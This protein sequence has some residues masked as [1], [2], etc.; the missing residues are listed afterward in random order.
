MVQVL[1]LVAGAVIVLLVIADVFLTVLYARIGAGIL[2]MRIARATWWVVSRIARL[3]RSHHDKV[4]S[5]CGPI[6]LVNLLVVWALLLTLGAALIIH[7]ALGRSVTLTTGRTPTDFISALYA[8]GSSMAI[9]RASD[10]TPDTGPYRVYFL[11]NSLLGASVISLT[12]TYLMQVYN[13]LQR[14]NTLA[15]KL[16]LQTAETS[17]AAELLAGLGARG[18]F[19]CGFTNLADIAVEMTVSLEA[20]HFYPV[21]FYFRFPRPIYGVAFFTLLALDEVS[22]IKSAL[23][24]DELGW[25]K[26]SVPVTQ[27]WRAA[28]LLVNTQEKRSRQAG[29]ADDAGTP[30]ADDIAR[31]GRRYHAAVRRLREAGVAT[32]SDDAEGARDY[33]ALR[34]RWHHPVM[35]A[36]QMMEYSVDQID[37]MA[38]HP[39]SSDARQPFAERRHAFGPSTAFDPKRR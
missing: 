24:D 34:A 27:L 5:F 17:D 35:R 25:L 37:P 8:G 33:V 14:R 29:A 36:M 18:S 7:P 3:F 20:H 15:Y 38:Q 28:L 39:E 6:I 4:L 32:R 13:A 2:S 23:S 30:T 16:Y 10:V 22:L 9:V 26:E 11:F 19:Q 1:E 12:I 21:L 31:W